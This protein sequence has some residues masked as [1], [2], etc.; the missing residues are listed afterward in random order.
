MVSPHT[1]QLSSQIDRVLVGPGRSR[2]VPASR[3]STSSGKVSVWR[4]REVWT[5]GGHRGRVAT[6]LPVLLAP[7]IPGQISALA[8]Q[9]AALLG[10]IL[11]FGLVALL[12]GSMERVRNAILDRFRSRPKARLGRQLSEPAKQRVER[13]VEIIL[14]YL[15]LKGSYEYGELPATAA[16]L[17]SISVL[18]VELPEL[19]PHLNKVAMYIDPRKTFNVPFAMAELIEPILAVTRPILNK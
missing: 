2:N 14:S 9:A 19:Q 18:Q 13:A 15:M 10:V 4:A 1:V 11:L 6:V 3:R 16:V 12:T 8:T 17:D 7:L 5:G